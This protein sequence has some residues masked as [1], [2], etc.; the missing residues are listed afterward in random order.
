MSST[1]NT[2]NSNLK[3]LHD[4]GKFVIFHKQSTEFFNQC[5]AAGKAINSNVRHDGENPFPSMLDKLKDQFGNDTVIDLYEHN[6]SGDLAAVFTASGLKEF[7]KACLQYG[8]DQNHFERHGNSKITEYFVTYLS[9]DIKLFLSSHQPWIDACNTRPTTDNFTKY[10]ILQ[11]L[12]NVGTGKT[13][14]KA[15]CAWLSTKQG[16]GTCS[17]FLDAV[18]T[19]KEITTANYGAGLHPGYIAIND[20]TGA[21]VLNG[22]NTNFKQFLDNFYVNNPTGNV[23]DLPAL[24]KSA[25]VYAREQLDDVPADQ[26][27]AALAAIVVKIINCGTCGVPID[28]KLNRYG[29]PFRFCIPCSRD[30]ASKQLSKPGP[31]IPKQS[32]AAKTVSRANVAASIGSSSSSVI[33]IGDFSSDEESEDD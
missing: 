20:L 16:T 19:G 13:K 21:I 27:A 28:S 24:L 7:K 25:A 33:P 30:Y 14:N 4:N 12:Y 1:L 23:L 9:P 15:L 5:G 10:R 6:P 17:Q 8:V 2:T 11:L 22:L 31:V 18:M 3:L 29:K 32:A 26:Y